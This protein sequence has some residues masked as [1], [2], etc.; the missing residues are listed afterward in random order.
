MTQKEPVALGA[1]VGV[2][3]NAVLGAL[4]AFGVADLT[5]E[6]TA[7]VFA[8]ANALVFVAGAFLTRRVVYSPYTVE[9]AMAEAAVDPHTDDPAVPS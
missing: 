8:V 5:A 6:Q 3:L 2:V 7:A 9:V 1:L 4:A